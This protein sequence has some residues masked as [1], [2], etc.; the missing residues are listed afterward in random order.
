MAGKK[1]QN[2]KTFC[3]LQIVKKSFKVFRSH[4]LKKEQVTFW[5]FFFLAENFYFFDENSK[6]RWRICKIDFRTFQN[7]EFFSKIC[8]FPRRLLKKTKFIFS[9]LCYCLARLKDKSD[10]SQNLINLFHKFGRKKN[11]GNF[12]HFCSDPFWQKLFL[13][14]SSKIVEKKL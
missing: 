3:Y 8:Q 2:L 7:F 9:K 10:D 12:C 5:H 14:L 4:I 1:W 11:R 6:I 13:F